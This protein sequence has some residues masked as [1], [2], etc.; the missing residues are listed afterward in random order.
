MMF[1]IV[2]H[3]KFINANFTKKFNTNNAKY[4]IL[5]PK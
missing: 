1:G 4:A 3:G 5:R 2:A